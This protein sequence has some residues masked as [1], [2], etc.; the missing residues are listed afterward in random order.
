M[1]GVLNNRTWLSSEDSWRF[2]LEASAPRS[3]LSSSLSL[4]ARHYQ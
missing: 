1:H 4:S 3:K 2:T